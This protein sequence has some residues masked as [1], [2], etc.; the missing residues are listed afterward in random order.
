MNIIAELEKSNQLV[1]A[2]QAMAQQAIEQAFPESEPPK[3]AVVVDLLSSMAADELENL[4]NR[5]TK[6]IS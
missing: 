6:A 5:L 3:W 4:H 1:G 2:I